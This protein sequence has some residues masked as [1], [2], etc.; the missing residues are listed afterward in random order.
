M[1]KTPLESKP[2]RNQSLDVLRCL[3]MFGVVLQHTFAVC[4]FGGVIAYSSYAVVDCLTH[5]SVDGFTSI[6]GWFGIRCTLRKLWRL[7]CLIFFCGTLHYFI[8]EV[9]RLVCGS[10]FASR[11]GI[12]LPHREW[13]Y[14]SYR[15]W[16]LGAYVK[17]MVLTIALNPLLDWL[18]KQKK[19]WG[20]LATVIF[21]GGNYLSKLWFPWPSHSPRTIIFVY[22]VVRLA[23][24]LG[25]KQVLEKSKGVRAACT[26]ALVCVFGFIAANAHWHLGFNSGNYAGPLAIT[27][28][29]LL[30]GIF[31]NLDFSS[32]GRFA[33]LCGFIA[34][35]MIS[36]YMLHWYFMETFFRPVPQELLARVPLLP[37]A[38]AFIACA[39]AIFTLCV[40]IDMTR[41]SVLKKIKPHLPEWMR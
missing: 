35:S 16:Y 8:Y 33:K 20:W 7:A 9:G 19:G 37:V 2:P 10:Y 40:L 41:R 30:V 38:V 6:S 15:Y 5:P 22:L 21:I 39:L 29:L 4:K 28:G 36:V 12:D 23:M 18:A 32:W 17:L 1:N 25:F 31:A 3:L 11:Y 13:G 26:I 34:P 27:A 14:E 24:M